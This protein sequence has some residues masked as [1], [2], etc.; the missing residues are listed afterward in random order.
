MKKI[1]DEKFYKKRNK[2]D[3]YNNLAFATENTI[4]YSKLDKYNSVIDIGCASGIL[5]SKLNIENKY[6]IDLEEA[7]KNLVDNT[8]HF[9]S[10][11]FTSLTCNSVLHKFEDIKYSFDLVICQE[12]IEHIPNEYSNSVFEL[13][14]YLAN[15]N[16][17]LIF[18]GAHI[19]QR[20]KNH[21]NCNHSSYF[22]DVLNRNFYYNS[23]M[24]NHYIINTGLNKGCYV[25]NTMIFT[26]DK[27]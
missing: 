18:S 27:Y 16:S 3:Y 17:T 14:D 1:Y 11:D 5:L 8:I 6:G 21:I 24:T 26:K 23:I 9:I 19:G 12:F 10:C 15:K 2:K 25:D 20:G 22:I 13:L 4:K 7:G